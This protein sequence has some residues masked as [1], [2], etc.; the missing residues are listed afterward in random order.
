M[1]LIR[2]NFILFN[3]FFL[4]YK[5]TDENNLSCE[6]PPMEIPGEFNSKLNLIYTYSVTFE[7]SIE[8]VIH[9]SPKV[10]T[11]KNWMICYEP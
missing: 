11:Q 2:C 1:L 6:G 8:S 3:Y 9:N 7:V 5:H 10:Q 4:S